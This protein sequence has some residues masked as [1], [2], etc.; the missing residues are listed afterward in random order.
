MKTA[1]AGY[2]TRRLVDVTH[3]VIVR[4]DDCGTEDGLTISKTSRR[5]DQFI[6]RTIGRI[7]AEDVLDGKKVIAKRG[8]L[9]DEQVQK[10]LLSPGVESI[11]V[12]SP[13]TCVL[14]YGICKMCY[15]WDFG[16]RKLAELGFPAGVVAAQSIGEPGTQLTMR[17][18]HTGGIVGLDVT[19]G[20]PRVE[21]LFEAR[22]PKMLAPIA[23]I[24]GKVD[25][26]EIDRGI[27]IKISG[28]D[29]VEEKHLVSATAQLQV[30]NGQQVPAG[31][32]MA[33]GALDVDQLVEVKGVRA[34]QEYL[35]HEIQTVYESQGIP[36]ND[37]HFEVIV[38]KMSDKARITDPGSTAFLHGELVDSVTLNTTN[39]QTMSS[40]G[41]P[42]AVT[43]VILGITRASLYTHSW[44]SAASFIETTKVLTE[45]ALEGK[46]DPLLG[47]KENVI[48]GRLI[49]TSEDR[50]AIPA[51]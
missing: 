10:L 11:V 14:P 18:K 39:A 37:K 2:L 41:K 31:W 17:I 8:D 23:G 12:R 33:S 44:L 43:Q 50:A 22:S 32:Q 29:G 3:D 13:L 21:E 45:A 35:I 48:I 47:L 40:G 49:P 27:M 36:I 6:K 51:S 16:Q 7:L 9:I 46:E 30:Q 28:K 38:R 19:Q 34:S 26:K 20:L 5:G 15:G 25:I 42:A 1:D 4:S 24:A